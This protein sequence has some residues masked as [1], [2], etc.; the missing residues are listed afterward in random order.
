M[1]MYTFVC[2]VVDVV[3]VDDDDD[4]DDGHQFLYAI[5]TAHVAPRK[6]LSICSK[7]V[8]RTFHQAHSQ[9]LCCGKL[10]LLKQQCVLSSFYDRHWSYAW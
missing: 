8:Q 3:D 5:C 1:R 2:V 10:Q 9:T 6:P 4:D 7:V